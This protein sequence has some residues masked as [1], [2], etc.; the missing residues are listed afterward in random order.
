VIIQLTSA[1]AELGNRELDLGLTASSFKW[2]AAR[3]LVR[4]PL[5]IRKIETVQMFKKAAKARVLQ[6][7]PLIPTE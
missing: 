4:I 5:K 6:N 7:I 1:E 2:R 3:S